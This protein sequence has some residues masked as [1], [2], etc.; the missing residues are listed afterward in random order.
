MEEEG[1][2]IELNRMDICKCIESGRGR[3]RDRVEED[4]HL[5]MHNKRR[6]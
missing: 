4:E 3:E 1:K 2:K 5:Q 6:G